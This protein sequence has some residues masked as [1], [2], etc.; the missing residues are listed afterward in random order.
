MNII[1]SVLIMTAISGFIGILLTFAKNTIGNYGF[2]EIKINDEKAIKVEGGQSLLD[3]LQ[4]E[5]IYIP[6]AC[7]GKGNCGYCKVKVLEGGGELLSTEK[8]YINEEEKKQ[9]FRLACQCK[10]RNSMKIEI[11]KELLDIKEFNGVVTSIDKVTDNIKH[12]I[13]KLN[14]SEKIIFKPGQYIQF[15]A[16]KYKGCNEEVQRAYSIASSP[17]DNNMI[18]LII[19]HVKE[20]LCSTYIH[21]YLK[22]GDKVRFTGPFGDFYYQDNERDM[23][24]I[25]AGTGMAPILSILK[26]MKETGI[27]RKAK[28]FFGAKTEDDLFFLEELRNIENEMFDFEFVPSLSRVSDED[29]W[30]G[31]RGRVTACIRELVENGDNKEAY[32][33]G[34]PRMIDAIVKELIAKGIDEKLIYYDKF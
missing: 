30:E 34:S 15:I 17:L 27:K 22:E 9:N 20:G 31:R 8:G 12:I 2:Q 23:I 14:N 11:P 3:A 18:E 1:I 28:F 19:G 6:S 13:I 21:N 24:M 10:V 32:L 33:C 26:M 16:P 5:K 29:E 25:A 4:E 7:G